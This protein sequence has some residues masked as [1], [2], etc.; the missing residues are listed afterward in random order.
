MERIQAQANKLWQIVSSPS[1][2]KAYQETLALTW[3]ILKETGQLLWLLLCL[4]L[5]AGDWFWK[6]SYKAG[7][8]ARVWID[9]MQTKVETPEE[10]ATQATSTA[11]FLSETGKSLLA[12]GQAT[13][14]RLLNTAKEQ[15][16]LEVTSEPP[17]KPVP[18][19]T[20]PAPP[21]AVSPSATSTTQPT[22]AIAPVETPS[23]LSTQALEDE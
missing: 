4:G 22:E 17:A 7:Q 9:A 14:T 23:E 20:P 10:E 15:L 16:G 6:K 18:V 19:E 1:T 11:D 2:V 13:V 5:V 12:T 3:A 21:K 8:D